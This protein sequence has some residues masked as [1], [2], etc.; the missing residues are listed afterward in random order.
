MASSTA[1]AQTCANCPI[2]GQGRAGT[3][4]DNTPPGW[5]RLLSNM[6]SITYLCVTCGEEVLDLALR[7]QEIVK[8]EYVHFFALVVQGRERAKK[9][10]DVGGFRG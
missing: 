5:V 8:D 9:S 4:V 10:L 1:H 3:I 7:L 2:V 6:G